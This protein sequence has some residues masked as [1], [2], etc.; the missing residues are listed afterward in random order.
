MP[1]PTGHVGPAW[2]KGFKCILKGTPKGNL[3]PATVHMFTVH[4]A[5]HSGDGEAFKKFCVKCPQSSWPW[6]LREEICVCEQSPCQLV[7]V[8]SRKCFLAQ[9]RIFQPA[10]KELA[11][12][13][14]RAF[15]FFRQ[16]EQLAPRQ[17]HSLEGAVS[18]TLQRV[19]LWAGCPEFLL[20]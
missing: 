3:S 11:K 12:V 17:K 7:A 9:S 4:T 1:L 15:A 20:A 8:G 18:F 14:T 2:S 16:A 19:F 10:W 6:D 13:F 5:V